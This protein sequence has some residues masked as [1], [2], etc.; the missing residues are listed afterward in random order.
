MKTDFDLIV[1]RLPECRE[2][3]L[4]VIGD[5]HVGAIEANIKGWEQFV[6][7]ILQDKNAYIVILGDMM[8]NAIKTSVSNVYE[9][10][11]RPRE[12]KRYLVSALSQL[13]ERILCIVPGNH[14]QRNK[15]VDDEPLY[16]V[17]CK[18]DLEDIYR[19]N[20]AFLKVCFGS[21]NAGG[22]N[23]KPLQV[24]TICCTH[25]A[26]GGIYTGATVNRNE[27]M[28]MFVNAD[29]LAVGHTH[30]GAITK[31]ARIEIDPYTNSVKMKTTTVISACSWLSY[32]GYAMRKMLL[33]SSAQD[34]DQ[35][36]TL[37]LG[38]TRYGRYV[39]TVW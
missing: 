21:R 18:L 6:Q 38:G 14:E 39:K 22:D 16:D 5:L 11:L 4:Y 29:I 10:V 25:G 13:T 2:A 3:R 7:K 27:R 17:A 19:P 35:P 34:P 24:Y 30:K 28:A 12:Q 36:Q 37:L 33:P 23:E 31:P 15:D 32:G 20:A 26:G 1:H 8:N 9:E